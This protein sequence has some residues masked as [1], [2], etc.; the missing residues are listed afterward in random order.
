MERNISFNW[1]NQAMSISLMKYRIWLLVKEQYSRKN[2][3]K[4]LKPT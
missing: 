1:Y 4:E 2:A 3:L